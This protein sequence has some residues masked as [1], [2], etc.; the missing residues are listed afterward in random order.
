[1]V[2]TTHT[3]FFSPKKTCSVEVIIKDTTARKKFSHTVCIYCI[4]IMCSFN[5]FAGN[6]NQDNIRDKYNSAY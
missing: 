3:F 5:N 6:Y 4:K 2:N 1:M